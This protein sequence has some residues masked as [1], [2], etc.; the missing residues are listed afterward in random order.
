MQERAVAVM[1]RPTD[2]IV[3]QEHS[4]SRQRPGAPSL[5][6][7]FAAKVNFAD[8]NFDIPRCLPSIAARL[9]VWNKPASA[10]SACAVAI[11]LMVPGVTEAASWAS[12]RA[13]G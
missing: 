1:S 6:T 4:F 5:E 12:R 7:I 11:V 8:Q 3:S 2:D 10:E 9:I 13:M